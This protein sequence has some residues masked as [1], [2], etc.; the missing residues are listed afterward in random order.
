MTLTEFVTESRQEHN[1]LLYNTTLYFEPG[2]HSLELDLAIQHISYLLLYSEPSGAKISCIDSSIRIQ[3]MNITVVQL[4]GLKFVNCGGNKII[5]VRELI[6]KDTTF[7]YSRNNLEES[8]LFLLNLTASIVRS[9]FI[10][11]NI[12]EASEQVGGAIFIYYC[13]VSF[14][15]STFNNN[16]ATD[17]GALYG[18]FSKIMF[19]KS[20]FE[21]N[22]ADL[23]GAAVYVLSSQ[24]T[25]ID[26]SF[27]ANIAA[28]RGSIALYDSETLI[29]TSI[30]G[31]NEAD[32][33]G[34]IFGNS[35]CIETAADNLTV[36]R[37]EASSSYRIGDNKSNVIQSNIIISS[38]IFVSNS[39]IQSG[40]ALTITQSIVSVRDSYF[41]TNT[42]VLGGAI[43]LEDVYINITRNEFRA[44]AVE[45]FGGGICL[46]YSQVVFKNNEFT[47]N[48]AHSAGGAINSQNSKA[49]F[50]SNTFQNNSAYHGGAISTV[51]CEITIGNDDTLSLHG[52][53]QLSMGTRQRISNYFQSNYAVKTGGALDALQSSIKF[54]HSIFRNNYANR[55]GAGSFKKGIT[56][57]NLGYFEG[58]RAHSGGAIYSEDANTSISESILIHNIAFTLDTFNDEDGFGGALCLLS[59]NSMISSNNFTENSAISGGALYIGDGFNII[60]MDNY[61]QENVAYYGGAVYSSVVNIT[62]SGNNFHKNVANNFSDLHNVSDYIGGRGGAVCILNCTTCIM[63]DIFTSNSAQNSGGAMFLQNCTNVI[64]NNDFDFNSAEHGGAILCTLSTQNVDSI[65]GSNFTCNNAHRTGGAIT[66]NRGSIN[67]TAVFINNTAQ[68]GGGSVFAFHC[69]ITIISSQFYNNSAIVGSGG[70]QALEHGMITITDSAFHSNTAQFGGALSLE[71]ATINTT[72]NKL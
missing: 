7:S 8:A 68:A 32:E 21:G 12:G 30:F 63:Y 62:I 56:F 24:I 23:N 4:S 71:H 15:N 22:Y 64:I 35:L 70:A 51:L 1:N 18:L 43:Y 25:I 14:I 45:G 61:F 60:I 31:N 55:G 50:L 38:S 39:A 29:Q 49:M 26:C 2:V 53:K 37:K 57:L 28:R 13:N 27:I 5:L 20:T 46:L 33:G 9:Y 36:R 11:N 48:S 59:S 42:A 47:A 3:L 65:L 6:I 69:N 10:S 19:T 40:G 16:S 34:V 67:I 54:S 66:I 41:E 58:N 44:N 17:G 72:N 52:Q